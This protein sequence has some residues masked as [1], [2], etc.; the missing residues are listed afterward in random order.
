[1]STHPAE[2]APVAEGTP[3]APE[4]TATASA[5][6]PAQAVT[7]GRR[8]SPIGTVFSVVAFFEAFTWAGLLVGMFLKYV[9]GTTEFGVFLFGRLHGGAFMVYLVVAIVAAIVLRWKWWVAALAILAAIPPL[10]TVVLEIW[11]HR[12][13]R[14]TRLAPGDRA[15]EG[16]ATEGRSAGSEPRDPAPAR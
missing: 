12:T 6:A 15:A 1:M 7:A 14:L 5:P 3:P 8:R 2:P 13:G 9:T 16:R 4:S 10:V 11:L